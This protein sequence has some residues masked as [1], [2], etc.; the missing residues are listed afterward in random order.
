MFP[1]RKL[2]APTL[3]VFLFGLALA[4]PALAQSTA[5]V[6]V[7]DVE[8]ILLESAKGKRA[9]EELEALRKQ[10]TDQ[11]RTM[12]EEIQQLRTRLQEGSLSLAED[13][14]AELRKQAEDKM[15]AFQRF[16]DDAQRELTK[17]RE[18]VLGSIEKEVF[19]VINAVGEEGGYTMIFNKF[20][21]GLVY[22]DEAID[23]TAEV[24]ER[25]NASPAAG[26]GG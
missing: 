7:I 3:L 24:I 23:I 10:K 14:I 18:E 15:I 8:R 12:Q 16:Q 9:L 11:M 6:A 2:V 19:P 22:A 26:T 20:N 4:L 21:S 13:R 25:F 1:T 5:K 17:K